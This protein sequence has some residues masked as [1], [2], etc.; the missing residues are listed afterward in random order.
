MS[1]YLHAAIVS[2]VALAVY[3]GS[4]NFGF[5]FDDIPG[6]LSNPAVT[7]FNSVSQIWSV[8]TLPW[9]PLVQL[10]YALT[11]YFVGF[12]AGA[13]HLT[14]VVLHALNSVLVFLI[15]RKLA[16][17][18]LSPKDASTFA[19]IAGLIHA[20]HPLYT[21]AVAYIWGRSSLLCA[22]FY[23]TAVLLML[24]AIE[25][26]GKGRY[27]LWAGTA[28]SGFLAWK[29]KEEAIALPVLIIIFSSSQETGK[30]RLSS[31]PRRYCFFSAKAGPSLRF[32]GRLARQG[33][34]SI[35][36][37]PSLPPVEY[38]LTHVKAKRLLLSSPFHSA[39]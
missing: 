30:L 19:L 22:M 7:G 3:A 17:R 4:F 38:F 5:V 13:F 18:W 9:R 33:L 25:R 21:E 37:N 10:T 31:Q 8:L 2:A 27:L 28:A 32:I 12:H 16:T 26:E 23:F 34:V 1:R 24:Y 11:F 29:S 14:N 36:L 6:I 35:G 20:T 15:A 39:D